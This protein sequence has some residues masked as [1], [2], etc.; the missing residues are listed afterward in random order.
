VVW[1]ELALAFRP[2]Q[3][4]LELNCGTG[5][6]AVYLAKKGVRILACDISPRMIEVSC[7]RAHAAEVSAL[8]DFRVIPTEEIAVLPEEGPFDGAFSNFS[9]LNCVEDHSR[10]SR[11]LGRLLKPN[12]MAGHTLLIGRVVEDHC[13]AQG[14]QFFQAHRFYEAWRQQAVPF[15]AAITH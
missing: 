11:N 6:D 14:L 10:V 1:Q 8:I 7:Q 12:A 2:G 13:W 4:I 3:R 5:I 15:D 9:G